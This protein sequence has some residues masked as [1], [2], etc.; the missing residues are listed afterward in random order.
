MIMDRLNIF[1]LTG[2]VL[3]GLTLAAMVGVTTFGPI[4][5]QF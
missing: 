1:L 2:G 4:I 5:R 3:G